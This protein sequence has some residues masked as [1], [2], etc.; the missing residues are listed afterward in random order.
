M[1]GISTSSTV[2]PRRRASLAG[3]LH[4][5]VPFHPLPRLSV[6]RLFLGGTFRPAEMETSRA[7]PRVPAG[8]GGRHVL[9]GATGDGVHR[10]DD[11]GGRADGALLRPGRGKIC[12]RHPDRAARC[13]RPRLAHRR[14]PGHRTG[15]R[16][17][18]SAHIQK[19]GGDGRRHESSGLVRGGL[20][21][22][23]QRNRHRDSDRSAAGVRRRAGERAAGLPAAAGSFVRVDIKAVNPPH[24]SWAIPVHAY[25]QRTGTGWKL[26]GFERLP[27][28]S[29]S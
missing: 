1:R 14:E 21:C 16:C 6:R 4:P 13:H 29:R 23:R 10:R 19:C 8:Q 2:A 22:L 24:P 27:D 20:V 11:S 15:A 26:V 28:G 17:L 3:L 12:R 7:E 25:F 5:G 18:G 9:G